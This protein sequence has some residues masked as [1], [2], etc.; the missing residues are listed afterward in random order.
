M[1]PLKP[2]DSLPPSLPLYALTGVHFVPEQGAYDER[3]VHS[4]RSLQAAELD[5]EAWAD[6]QSD[7]NDSRHGRDGSGE[8]IKVE[9]EN[10][11]EGH[12]YMDIYTKMQ[13][14]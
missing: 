11:L 8:Y 6:E 1:Q 10:G 13:L 7:G 5:D 3:A 9:I 12:E 4:P 14:R 2:I